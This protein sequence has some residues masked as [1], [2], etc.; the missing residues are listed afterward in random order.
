[1]LR[2]DYPALFDWHSPTVVWQ[3]LS[4]GS[5]FHYRF[6]PIPFRGGQCI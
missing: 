4:S 2:A 3:I 1:V 5:H 6:P